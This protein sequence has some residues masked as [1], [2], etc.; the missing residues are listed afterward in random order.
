MKHSNF[1]LY[2][3]QGSI[4]EYIIMVNIFYYIIDLVYTGLE[5]W[6]WA[7][8]KIKLKASICADV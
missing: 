4:K 7:L 6:V 8:W 3:V 1:S 5:T 2:N